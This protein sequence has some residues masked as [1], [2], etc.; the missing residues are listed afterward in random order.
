MVRGCR[1]A[2]LM[3]LIAGYLAS[4]LRGEGERTQYGRMAYGILVQATLGMERCKGLGEGSWREAT[5]GTAWICG[6]SAT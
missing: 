4:E 2:A 1:S 6:R 5:D 3:P